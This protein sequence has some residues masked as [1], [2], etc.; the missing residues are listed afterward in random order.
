MFILTKW[1]IGALRRLRHLFAGAPEGQKKGEETEKGRVV[2]LPSQDNQVQSNRQADKPDQAKKGS[3]F[4][5]WSA[6]LRDLFP[7]GYLLLAG[8]YALVLVLLFAIFIFRQGKIPFLALPGEIGNQIESGQPVGE[9]DRTEHETNEGGLEEGADNETDAGAGGGDVSTDEVAGKAT[10]GGLSTGVAGTLQ[11]AGVVTGAGGGAAG[12]TTDGNPSSIGGNSATGTVT[13]PPAGEGKPS[14]TGAPAIEAGETAGELSTS[15]APPLQAASPLP[16]WEVSRPYGAYTSTS[17][18]SGGRLHN[19][20]RGVNLTATPGAPVAALWDG[21][22]SKTGGGD[23]SSYS[24]FVVLEHSGDYVTFYGNLREVWV[25]EGDR[26]SRGEHLGLLPHYP[27]L[28]PG[29]GET[30]QPVSAAATS[31]ASGEVREVPLKTIYKGAPGGETITSAWP[32]EAGNP[33]LYLEVRQGH[34]YLDPLPYIGIR[35]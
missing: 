16:V 7:R 35:N 5:A 28:E 30:A 29:S 13:P 15:T 3:L 6:E 11:G 32:F 21:R 8:V 14:S 1:K 25:E 4:R 24:R 10:G 26:I 23:D 18:P 9:A 12:R 27:P 22:V 2:R 17:L 31:G 19:L 34:S 33:L 20:A